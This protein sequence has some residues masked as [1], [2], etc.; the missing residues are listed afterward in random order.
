MF[1]KIFLIT[2]RTRL[3]ELIERFNTI[4]QARFY[5]ESAG[6]DFKE[7]EREDQVYRQA[8]E[9]TRQAIP[10]GLKLHLIDRALT[11]T[12]LFT[13]RDL[14]L[15]LGQDGLVANTAKYVHGQPI[16][17]INPDPTL[18][19]GILLPFLPAQ[20]R[21]AVAQTLTGRSKTR[22]V[23]MAEALTNDGQ[24]ILAFNDLFI[25]AATQ[26][27]ARYTITQGATTEHQSSS[28][29]LVSTGAG[30]T[31]WI[32]S[33]FNMA[34]GIASAMGGKP[35]Q[36]IQMPWEDPRLFYVTR[37]PFIS[38]HSTASLV[39]GWIAAG[40][41]LRVESN[42]PTGGCIVSDGVPSDSIDFNAGA[43]LTIQRAREQ[44]LLVTP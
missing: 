22:S 12:I 24:R 4:G 21:E 25:G 20:T 23:T 6:G 42:M 28:G 16:I 31:G 1:E 19:D 32:S 17:A 44:A 26:V 36:P 11:P 8:V 27:S 7:Y 15:T 18:F 40:Q 38:L 37:E 35:P 34:G 33:A 29:L 30:S 9:T 5:I 10:Q 2:R 14:I 3:A 39:A 13:Q 43:I 41:T